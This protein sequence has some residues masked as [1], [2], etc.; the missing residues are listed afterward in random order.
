[1]KD[2]KVQLVLTGL[3]GKKNVRIRQLVD[4]CGCRLQQKMEILRQAGG[5]LKM[6]DIDGTDPPGCAS[7]LMHTTFPFPDRV[8]SLN[9]LNLRN[10]FI[11]FFF[12]SF[13]F[14]FRRTIICAF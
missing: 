3:G 9:P 5:K 14:V 6:K 7:V 1:M 4:Q 11:C 12:F 13:F 10:A 8:C 2:S